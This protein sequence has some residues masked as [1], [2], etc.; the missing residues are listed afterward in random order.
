VEDYVRAGFGA[1]PDL[2]VAVDPADLN[3]WLTAEPGG[4]VMNMTLDFAALLTGGNPDAAGT[5][6]RKLTCEIDAAGPRK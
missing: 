2:G 1:G 5:V 3:I 6:A 4:P